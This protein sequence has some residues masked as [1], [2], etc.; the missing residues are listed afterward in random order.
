MKTKKQRS[1]ELRAQTDNC[2]EPRVLAK[3]II[4]DPDSYSAL[5]VWLAGNYISAVL[6]LDIQG[7]VLGG[8]E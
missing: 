8:E 2:I 5:E 6:L 4:E 3:K 7:R 1:E